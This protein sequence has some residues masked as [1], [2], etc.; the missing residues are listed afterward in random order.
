MSDLSPRMSLPT[1]PNH[2]SMCSPVPPMHSEGST[3]WLSASPSLLH[4]VQCGG[5]FA[6]CKHFVDM[7]VITSTAAMIE[8]WEGLMRE[9][10]APELLQEFVG[11]HFGP[12]GR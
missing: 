5:V 3:S 6:D 11:R 10:I 2:G 9:A 7:P 8:E 4:A 12:P 1:L